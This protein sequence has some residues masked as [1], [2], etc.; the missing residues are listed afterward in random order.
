ML[1]THNNIIMFQLL[2]T[3]TSLSLFEGHFLYHIKPRLV[4]CPFS[5]PENMSRV[6]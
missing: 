1:Y 3:V 6:I 2:R 5:S 4:V